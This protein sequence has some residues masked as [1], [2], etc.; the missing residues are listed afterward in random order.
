LHKKI[1]ESKRARQQLIDE[2]NLL[3]GSTAA[4]MQAERRA[5]F[6]ALHKGRAPIAGR[7]PRP[8]TLAHHTALNYLQ[9][10]NTLNGRNIGG[11]IEF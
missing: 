9:V 2:R 4:R 8:Y 3:P 10:P 7:P 5:R 1:A 11:V 6:A